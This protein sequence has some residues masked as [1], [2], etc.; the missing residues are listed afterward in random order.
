MERLSLSQRLLIN[1]QSTEFMHT[2]YSYLEEI[3]GIKKNVLIREVSSFQWVKCVVFINYFVGIKFCEF[4][5]ACENF[6]TNLLKI[7]G[8]AY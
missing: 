5:S 1:V 4:R 7:V 2:I 8:M 3:A 6:S